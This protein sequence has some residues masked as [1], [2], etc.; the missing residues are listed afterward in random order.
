MSARSWNI[1]KTVREYLVAHS[2][3]DSAIKKSLRAKTAKLEWGGMQISPEQGQFMAL[4]VEMLGARKCLEVG[5]FTGYSALCVA[6]AMPKGGKLIACDVS[7]EWTRIGKPFWKKAGVDKKIDLR[8][9]PGLDTLKALLK[10][11]HA[12]TFDFAFIDADKENYDGYYE[13]T[14]K[15][16]RKGGVVGFDNVLWGGSVADPKKKSPSTDALRKLN[17]KLH[18]DKRVTIA[19]IPIGDGLTLVR[20]R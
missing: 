19:M 17:T 16:L 1:D 14:L 9:G 20:K 13:A 18:K 11:G 6:E 7:D 15:L 5:T 10:E 4:V 8:L 2:V 12:G 3:R